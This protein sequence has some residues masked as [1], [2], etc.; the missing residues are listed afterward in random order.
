M[1]FSI[2]QKNFFKNLQKVNSIIIKNN[3]NPIL[4][5]II[6]KFKKNFLLLISSSN[7]IELIIKT[8]KFFGKC[9]SEISVLG[10]KIFEICKILPKDSILDI[11]LKNK[12]ILIKSDKSIFQLLTLKTKNFPRFKKDN[13]KKIFSIQSNILKNMIDYT[14]FSISNNDIR[15]YFNGLLLKFNNFNRIFCTTSTNG[16]RLSYYYTKI[17]TNVKKF[18]DFSIIIP[19]KS[20]LEL[21]KIISFKTNKII[22]IFLNENS[23]SFKTENITFTSK[24]IHEKFPNFKKIFI[25]KP[26]FKIKINRK[27]LKKYLSYASILSHQLTKGVYIKFKKN[28]ICVIKSH[29]QEENVIS[30][31]NFNYFKKTI[32][33]SINVNYLLNVI[34]ILK[35]K[36]IIFKLK[37]KNLQIQIED[38]KIKELKYIIMPLQI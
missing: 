25:K 10:N 17:S 12:K 34:N 20:V 18:L 24:I 19:R 22:D 21:N 32:K 11:I 29:N 31:F 23:V 14:Y 6:I 28:G 4:E 3:V 8:K 15:N 2:K 13:L 37:K 30:K 16:H 7:D 26:Y 27:K 36:Y 35:N 9:T 33:I 5:N 1:K 38:P